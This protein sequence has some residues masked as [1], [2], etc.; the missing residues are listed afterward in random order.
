[1]A[2]VRLA[3]DVVFCITRARVP[4][5]KTTQALLERCHAFQPSTGVGPAPTTEPSGGDS[6][7]PGHADETEAAAPRRAS[8]WLTNGTTSQASRSSTS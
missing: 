8:A 6:D 5:P 1:M 4:M 3:K 7:R 2:L